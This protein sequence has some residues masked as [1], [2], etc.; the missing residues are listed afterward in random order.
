[1]RF[2]TLLQP[3]ASLMAIGAK[4]IETR[5]WATTYRGVVGIGA[6]QGRDELDWCA[7]GPFRSALREAGIFGPADL[8]FGA[9]LALGK[10]VDCRRTEVVEPKLLGK[11]EHA[12]GNYT[13]GRWAW[14][15]RDVTRLPEP[16]PWRGRLGLWSDRTLEAVLMRV[17]EPARAIPRCA[18]CG[19]P[20]PRRH[21][22]G[23][24]Y[25]DITGVL[26]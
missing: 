24:S 21:A 18:E 23:C 10:L 7:E 11:P 9:I 19:S 14:L 3:W 16:I 8:P 6:S 1:M 20:E 26:R 5:S 2:L 13:A 17:M 25:R 22:P 4:T 12:F 15:F